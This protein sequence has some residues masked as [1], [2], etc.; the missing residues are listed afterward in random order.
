LA[1][2]CGRPGRRV[3]DRDA[4]VGGAGRRV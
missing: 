2:P 1:W 4:R 3:R